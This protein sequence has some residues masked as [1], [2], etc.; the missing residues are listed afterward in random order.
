[1]LLKVNKPIKG[2]QLT[3]A[4]K[5]KNNITNHHKTKNPRLSRRG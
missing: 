2:K 1:V 5:R 4:G 3:I